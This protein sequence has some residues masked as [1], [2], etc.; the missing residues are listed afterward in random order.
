MSES[1]IVP[2]A[3][4]TYNCCDELQGQGLREL[5]GLS[6]KP[7]I[8]LVGDLHSGDPIVDQLR[9][10][11]EVVPVEAPF[12]APTLDPEIEGVFISSEHFSEGVWLGKLLQNERILE[13]LP[14][15]VA[16]LNSENTI[17]WANDC[18]KNWL[19]RADL[20]GSNFYQAFGNPGDSGSGF[21]S[22]PYGSRD[23]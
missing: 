3:D 12:R 23:G 17:L 22:V 8:L 11:F 15:G 2:T 6:T 14:D 7:K 4:E 18:L 13:G 1:L 19:N 16:L 20:A 9:S 10:K 21:L 5:G